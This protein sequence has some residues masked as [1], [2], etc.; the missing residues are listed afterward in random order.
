MNHDV[1]TRAQLRAYTTISAFMEIS[2]PD[3]RR[4]W[5]VHAPLFDAGNVTRDDFPTATGPVYG[6][7]AS[8]HSSS[9]CRLRACDF[10]SLTTPSSFSSFPHSR[11]LS[12]L[13]MDDDVSFNERKDVQLAAPLAQLRPSLSDAAL[14]S[15]ATASVPLVPCASKVSALQEP[16]ALTSVASTAKVIASFRHVNVPAFAATH[17]VAVSRGQT[18]KSSTSVRPRKYFRFVAFDPHK[19]SSCRALTIAPT[20]IRANSSTD[21]VVA[22]QIGTKTPTPVSYGTYRDIPTCLRAGDNSRFTGHAVRLPES[23]L[24]GVVFDRTVSSSIG[25]YNRNSAALHRQQHCP[26]QSCPRPTTSDDLYSVT[27]VGRRRQRSVRSSRLRSASSTL[28]AVSG[29]SS[30]RASASRPLR[31]GL[32]DESCESIGGSNSIDR[33]G[34]ADRE[35]LVLHVA[36][37]C[38]IRC[39]ERRRDELLQLCRGFS[40]SVHSSLSRSASFVGRTLTWLAL[41]STAPVDISDSFHCLFVSNRPPDVTELAASAVKFASYTLAF[42]HGHIQRLRDSLGLVDSLFYPICALVMGGWYRYT[43]SRVAFAGLCMCLVQSTVH[44]LPAIRERVIPVVY[45]YILSNNARESQSFTPEGL[46]GV[47]S[48][49]YTSIVCGISVSAHDQRKLTDA[50]AKYPSL[51]KGAESF[52]GDLIAWCQHF[53][54]VLLTTL[55]IHHPT[56]VD[57]LADPSYDQFHLDSTAFL[58]KHFQQPVYNITT[59]NQLHVLIERGDA[60]VT[61][62]RWDRVTAPISMLVNSSLTKL[63][64]ILPDFAVVA[65]MF[66]RIEP[67]MCYLYSGPGQG[68][69]N[70]ITILVG[71]MTAYSYPECAVEDFRSCPT[72]YV[73][74]R[75][76][77]SGEFWEGA[78]G[79]KI[80]VMDEFDSIDDSKVTGMCQAGQALAIGNRF[81]YHLNMAHLESKSNTYLQ[82]E[83]VVLASNSQVPH[84]EQ[85]RHV[86]ALYRRL[87]PCFHVRVRH[88]YCHPNSWNAPNAEGVPNWEL[89]TATFA[90]NPGGMTA[91]WEFRPYRIVNGVVVYDDVWYTHEQLLVLLFQYHAR[92]VVIRDSLTATSSAEFTRVRNNVQQ[93]TNWVPTPSRLLPLDAANIAEAQFCPHSL[94]FDRIG[95]R[96]LA[97]LTSYGLYLPE[98]DPEFPFVAMS[99]LCLHNM[100]LL[101]VQLGLT[102][103]GDEAA[104]YY[105]HPYYRPLMRLHLQSLGADDLSHLRLAHLSTVVSDNTWGR[106]PLDKCCFDLLR[107]CNLLH[108]NFDDP[109]VRQFLSADHH[110]AIELYGTLCAFLTNSP[111]NYVRFKQIVKTSMKW[112]AVPAFIVCAYG[113]YQ[114]CKPTV[115]VETQSVQPNVNA[116]RLI[117]QHLSKNQQLPHRH[118]QSEFPSQAFES[119]SRHIYKLHTDDCIYGYCT[120]ISG[121][122]LITA[123]HV[124]DGALQACEPGTIL[125]VTQV[126]PRDVDAPR[127]EHLSTFDISQ[128]L[129]VQTDEFDRVVV[130]K[131]DGNWQPFKNKPNLL[132]DKTYVPSSLELMGYGW[133]FAHESPVMFE[134]HTLVSRGNGPDG[135]LEYDHAKSTVAGESGKPLFCIVP[136]NS[137]KVVGVLGGVCNVVGR[138]TRE[139]RRSYYVPINYVWYEQACAQVKSI[140]IGLSTAALPELTEV[141]LQNGCPRVV[142]GTMHGSYGINSKTSLRKSPLQASLSLLGLDPVKTPVCLDWF[143]ESGELRHPLYQLLFRYSNENKFASAIHARDAAR[144]VLERTHRHI[145]SSTDPRVRSR[146][147][148]KLL[149]FEEAVAGIPGLFKGIARNTS[150]G[151]PYISDSNFMLKGGRR[152]FLGR[153]GPV[154]FNTPSMLE[155]RELCAKRLEE[156]NSGHADQAYS[157]VFLKDELRSPERHNAP[158]AIDAI[159]LVQFIVERQLFGGYIMATSIASPYNGTALGLNPYTQ[160]GDL[161]RLLFRNGR[162]TFCG[163]SPRHDASMN[164]NVSIGVVLAI[165]ESYHDSYSCARQASALGYIFPL[166]VIMPPPPP[167]PGP[168]RVEYFKLDSQDYRRGKRLM[169]VAPNV[170]M[171]PGDGITASANTHCVQSMHIMAYVAATGKSM[172]TYDSEVYDVVLGDDDVVSSSDPLFNARSYRQHQESIGMGY[173]DPVTKLP[174]ERPY[175]DESEVEF[176]SRKF[177]FR[178]EVGIVAPLSLESIFRQVLWVRKTTTDQEFA[179][180]CHH[181]LLE[182]S[183]HGKEAYESFAHKICTA[184]NLW[185]PNL[186]PPVQSYASAILEVSQLDEPYLSPG[187]RAWRLEQ[188][189]DQE[190]NPEINSGP[191]LNVLDPTGRVLANAPVIAQS[192]VVF[193]TEEVQQTADVL[194]HQARSIW[195][196]DLCIGPHTPPGKLPLCGSLYDIQETWT[197][198]R[199]VLGVCTRDPPPMDTTTTSTAPQTLIDVNNRDSLPV[200]REDVGAITQSTTQFADLGPGACAQPTTTGHPLDVDNSCAVAS[201]DNQSLVDY[202][203]KPQ[204]FGSYSWTTEAPL[205]TLFNINVPRDVLNASDMFLNRLQYWRGFRG[206]L[207]VQFEITS[208]AGQA[209]KLLA[210]WQPFTGITT[211]AG[212]RYATRWFHLMSLHQLPHLEIDIAVD[213]T[214]ELYIPCKIPQAY[215]ELSDLITATYLSWGTLSLTPYTT[216]RGGGTVTINVRTFFE[217]TS[218]RL[219]NPTLLDTTLVAGSRYNR[220]LQVGRRKN[221]GISLEVE[222]SSGPVSR[223]LSKVSSIAK[224]VSTI[225]ILADVAGPVSWVTAAMAGAASLLGYSNPRMGVPPSLMINRG[226]RDLCTTDQALPGFCYS[227]TGAARV[228]PVLPGGLTDEDEMHFGYLMSLSTYQETIAWTTSNAVDTVLTSGDMMQDMG[229]IQTTN[230]AIVYTHLAPWRAVATLFHMYHVGLKVKI[231]IA[232]SSFHTGKLVAVYDCTHGATSPTQNT[233]TPLPCLVMDIALGNEWTFD[234][235]YTDNDH[236]ATWSS[237]GPAIPSPPGGRWFLMVVT[238]LKTFGTAAT[239]VDIV[240]EYSAMADSTFAFPAG[241]AYWE[242]TGATLPTAQS[243]SNAT[244][245]SYARPCNPVG[246]EAACIGDTCHSLRTFLKRGEDVTFSTGDTAYS[247]PVNCPTGSLISDAGAGTLALNRSMAWIQG[248]YALSRGSLNYCVLGSVAAPISIAIPSRYDLA[249]TTSTSYVQYLPANVYVDLQVPQYHINPWKYTMA[250]GETPPSLPVFE[251][252]FLIY[253]HSSTNTRVRVHT[254]AADDFDLCY[255]IGIQPL[256]ADSLS[257]DTV[258]QNSRLVSR[259]ESQVKLSHNLEPAPRPSSSVRLADD[260]SDCL[261]SALPARGSRF[262][263]VVH[264]A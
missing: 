96:E 74:I 19:T 52:A 77:N 222:N 175:C 211:V 224:S 261:S 108:A 33:S 198:H 219:V 82:S 25:Y 239:T 194:T 69:S 247:W 240:I 17:S 56:W 146:S 245:G 214:A 249:P 257:L 78:S 259:E 171:G 66:D 236:F 163:D 230:T 104:W 210:V 149:T 150:P 67:V 13:S 16:G 223:V 57:H 143:M 123:R 153:D 48:A 248:W 206:D 100:V 65:P 110:A 11:R 220:K 71:S 23:G 133:S 101:S 124:L 126:F 55:G 90:N 246:L 35:C 227:F 158:R 244:A 94:V 187:E 256:K 64:T 138:L 193:R 202:F 42:V 164:P 59:K 221:R 14:R 83:F 107:T 24:Y 49:V 231:K 92:N 212:S 238:P 31:D 103:Y 260:S 44:C 63:R 155:L 15:V 47:L 197:D 208:N 232:K 121:E 61:S 182:M 192:A 233:I 81:P 76:I 46:V 145:R 18:V 253:T 60:I 251:T 199:G 36:T 237:T 252:P 79:Q 189:S 186:C 29:R 97:A 195:Q 89:V 200:C 263:S 117:N 180:Q 225:P 45:D 185:R 72:N 139:T 161:H 162:K 141:E 215:Y 70:Y 105:F 116:R 154:D 38:G 226:A 109:C 229:M 144:I 68:K 80:L 205:T 30:P 213:K 8:V 37:Q 203:T 183:L 148:F 32:V 91:V 241:D 54:G 137:L 262:P 167:R 134:H 88:I 160:W 216:L 151:W 184:F 106:T 176:L 165:D 255:F 181:A 73:L 132:P 201:Y 86:E 99:D 136:P 174:I 26:D 40:R 41:R 228:A 6:S 2:E 62:R 112:L 118:Q 127:I 43:R 122:F 166:R 21:P 178:P 7:G 93:Q 51:K 39:S 196:T 84:S 98:E 217:P 170:G 157:A 207:R 179:L 159:N 119:Y 173:T 120:A 209:G 190:F 152:Q 129:K 135:I 254:C 142:L 102:A 177:V 156:L 234:L 53:L 27:T 3:R 9:S 188:T 12:M 5:N 58:D 168:C 28:P 75:H 50:I 131:V 130:C 258:K 111:S 204:F 115:T 235:P 34:A 22:E 250:Y 113:L 147:F 114:F 191:G 140:K 242:Q 10:C 4:D 1:S 169:V 95:A 125:Q 243:I 264:R 87:K 218:V 85:L 172:S 20:S 128:C